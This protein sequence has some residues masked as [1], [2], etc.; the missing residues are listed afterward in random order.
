LFTSRGFSKLVGAEGMDLENTP[1]HYMSRRREPCQGCM[2]DEAVLSMQSTVAEMHF[3]FDGDPGLYNAKYIPIQLKDSPIFFEILRRV[4]SNAP[5][6][7][8]LGGFDDLVFGV[9]HDF[10]N[11]LSII[12][13][14]LQ[15]MELGM[16]GPI[17]K[18]KMLGHIERA[19]SA[20]Q[21]GAEICSSTMSLSSNKTE[22]ESASV[23][24]IVT[25]AIRLGNS[26]MMRSSNAGKSV[27]I[28]AGKIDEGLYAD[29]IA[30]EVQRA[31]LN[32]IINAVRHGFDSGNSGTVEVNAFRKGGKILIE[33]KNDGKEISRSVQQKLLK[34]RIPSKAANHGVGMLHTM[35]NL[36]KFGAELSFS[37]ASGNTA[38]TITL[39]KTDTKTP[40]PGRPGWIPPPAA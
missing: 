15:L 26:F 17:D 13:G 32:I 28:I 36:E 10:N 12:S 27:N 1:C 2:G 3:D 11:V 9:V 5:E 21:H 22:L 37:S 24:E 31:V 25:N 20:V 6:K 18:R 38:F 4:E 35:Q 29:I 40:P 23:N 34:E 33:V 7:V 16:R 8:Q 14:G 19:K 30:N 39:R